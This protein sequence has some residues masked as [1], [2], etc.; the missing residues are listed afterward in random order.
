MEKI[1]GG[2]GR[3]FIVIDM[4]VFGGYSFT[5]YFFSFLFGRIWVGF[6]LKLWCFFLSVFQFLYIY[7]FSLFPSIITTRNMAWRCFCSFIFTLRLGVSSRVLG[8]LFGVMA[9]LFS[10]SVPP[11]LTHYLYWL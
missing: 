11:F 10:L 9:I 4:A 6:V 3:Q 2:W 1:N 5:K 8:W 7:V